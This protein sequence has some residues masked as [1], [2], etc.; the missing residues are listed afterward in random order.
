V[1]RKIF[2]K[3]L[4]G[5]KTV[6]ELNKARSIPGF[7]LK[8]QNEALKEQ[9]AWAFAGLVEKGMFILGENVKALEVEIAAYCGAKFGIGVASGSD[10]L[11]LA[12]LACGIGPGDE[13]ITTPFTFFATAGSIARA[14]ARPVF[15]D[16]D[17]KIYNI[18]PVFVEEKITPRT[19]AIIP[20]H[21]YG[22]PADM[23]RI[24]E[25]AQRHNLMVIEDA[26]QA[27]GAKYRGKRVGGIGDAGCISFF[28][29]KNLGAFGDGGMVVTS[30]PEIAERVRVLRVHGSS[31][32]YYHDELGCNSR[33]DELQAA[34]L[35]VKFT[36][37]EAWAER[38]REIAALY[39]KFFAELQNAKDIEI[40]L[41]AE[42]DYS[43]HVYHQYTI[44]TGRR[45]EL[46][47]FLKERGVG[48][49]VYYPLPMH[50]QPVFAPLG[51]KQ[52]DFPAAEAA[53][54]QVLSLP[55]F[56]ELTN[57]EAQQVAEAVAGFFN[58][59]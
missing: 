46:Q 59:K 25:I 4:E 21:L 42:P 38:R 23:D 47:A 8:R 20:V 44:Q 49:T 28:P 14:G 52:G 19:R 12:L 57:E 56:P 2:V 51:Y 33:L 45:D 37:L 36:R 26:A 27:L 32:K 35:R 6:N 13:V 48:S 15:T 53:A 31:K 5:K 7:S 10:A 9:L 54:R 3:L 43:F 30:N 16:I 1:V 29:T 40:K 24:M 18:D 22:C 17:P 50:L 34:I 39:N 55:M 41:P 11:Y 58:Q